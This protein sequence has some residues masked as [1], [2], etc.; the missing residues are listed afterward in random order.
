MKLFT[1]ICFIVA[2]I[3]L[4]LGILGIAIGMGM[5]ADAGDLSEM[6]IYISPYHQVRV[7]GVITEME[8]EIRE[9]MDDI[10]DNV[11][12]ESF[13]IY[14]DKISEHRESVN[15]HNHSSSEG[16]I[17]HS[18]STVAED[19]RRLEVDVQN[20]EIYIFSTEEEQIRFDSNRKKEIGR[21]EGKT[22][23]LVEETFL[24]ETLVLEV[25]IPI[26]LLKEMDIK[27][28]GG[29]V[30]ADKLV[31][32]EVSIEID[33]GEV[34]VNQMIVN[35]QADIQTNA[36]KI[37]VGFFEGPKLEMDCD[38]GAIMVVCEGNKDDYNYKM[39]CGMGQITFDEESYS[40][41][42][43]KIHINNGSSKLI[44]AEC[45]MGEIILEFPNSL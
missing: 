22:L 26:G 15:E 2:G 17:Y 14:E 42:G 19:I 5:G 33:A 7:S 10:K 9:E 31:A 44:E 35:N 43:E 4:G 34:E 40:G 45:N 13:Y 12:E 23:K 37:V 36:G 18:Y 21:V 20:A 30:N 1:K 41:L 11:F 28:A 24:E 32:D 6:G 29:I 16:N 38:M 27:A 3:A 39:E 8:E 25:Y